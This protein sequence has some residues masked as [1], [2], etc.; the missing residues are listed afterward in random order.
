MWFR[1]KYEFRC[2]FTIECNK[3]EDVYVKLVTASEYILFAKV[4]ERS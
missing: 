2:Y 4:Y 3:F 1:E